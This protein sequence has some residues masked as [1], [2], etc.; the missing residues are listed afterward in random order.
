MEVAR[1]RTA[2]FELRTKTVIDLKSFMPDDHILR[3]MD[4]ILDLTFIRKLTAVCYA[5]GV[6][7]DLSFNFRDGTRTYMIIAKDP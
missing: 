4:R 2:V 7:I 1:T 6:Q 5:N 3:E